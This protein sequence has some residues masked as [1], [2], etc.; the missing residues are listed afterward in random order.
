MASSTVAAATAALT[1]RNLRIASSRATTA[2][3]IRRALGIAPDL[4]AVR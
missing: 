3:E 4:A 2:G 1:R